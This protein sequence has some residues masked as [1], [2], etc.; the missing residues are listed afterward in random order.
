MASGR[1]AAE[2]RWILMPTADAASDSPR[3]VAVFGGGIAGLTVAHEL[4][5]RG[6]RVS[7]YESTDEIGG[8]F[9]SGRQPDSNMPT[10]FSWHGLGPWYHNVF[11]LL[12][13]IPFDADGSVYERAL[14]RPIDF[15]IFPNAGRAAFFDHG[16]RSIPRMFRWSPWEFARW[17][18][19]ML[20]VWSA[21]R[22]TFEEYAG[23]NA[24][25]AWRDTLR[26][27]GYRTW[28]SCFGPWIGSD[29]TKVS[30]HTAG[31][32]FCKQL[33]SQPA[34]WHPADAA[35]DAWRHGA[36]DG[37]LLF[38]GPS[39]EYWF[40]RWQAALQS[41][42]VTFALSS[43]LKQLDYDGAKIVGV[44]LASG[45]RVTADYYVVAANPF[46]VAEIL[47]RT[48]AL[49]D[50]PP[51]SSFP[52]LLQDGEH[53]QV[54]F[55]LAFAEPVRFPRERTAVVVADSPYNL[56]LFAEEQVWRPD[57]AL[58]DG[59][60]SLWTGTSCTGNVPGIVHGLPVRRCTKE[61]FID[62]IRAQ[63][64]ACG[65]LDAMIRE[66]NAGR[67][68]ADFPIRRIEVWHEWQFSPDGIRSAQPKWVTTTHTQPHQPPQRTP[69]PNLLLAGAHT[70]T[71]ADVWSIEAAVESGRRAAQA[72]DRRVVVLPQH[73][74]AI[75]RVLG[76][77]DDGL[78]RLGLP[79]VLDSAL[80]VL[81]V[82]A[83]L[84]ACF[85]W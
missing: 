77:I 29:W 84:A 58:G 74:P 25:A 57:V 48:P 9:R 47:A 35:G 36:R 42:G 53:L 63:I 43:P 22:R 46:A 10:E 39:T 50:L 55:R 14:S 41:A 30:L 82:L 32:F 4:V 5:R 20:R 51:F 59:V 28:R 1:R 76:G 19:L 71:A 16:L 34:H 85:V 68:L 2:A 26:P 27:V 45:A 80:V 60:K 24:A 69:V 33:T 65:A 81:A 6:H 15:G 17:A 40:A 37:W 49:R 67:G 13:Q 52:P 72:I 23:L 31:Q 70:R 62:E 61:Q 66:A 21:N 38:R 18:W 44:R 8:F 83:G 78:Y 64:A 12:K 3:N 73:R 11:D 56:T 7:V 75:L 79:H 54:S